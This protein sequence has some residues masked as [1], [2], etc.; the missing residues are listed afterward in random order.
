MLFR[1]PSRV[2]EVSTAVPL[3][4]AFSKAALRPYALARRSA[5]GDAL[6]KPDTLAP[7]SIPDT[8]LVS[9]L[10]YGRLLCA[11]VA[12]FQT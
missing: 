6:R 12:V 2:L 5:L 4:W 1:R 3:P 10:Q 9:E 7:L 11:R 8:K